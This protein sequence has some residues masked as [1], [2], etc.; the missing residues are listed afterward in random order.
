MQILLFVLLSI[1]AV[2]LFTIPDKP[3]RSEP[4]PVPVKLWKRPSQRDK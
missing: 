4:Q 3:E 2:L 1:A